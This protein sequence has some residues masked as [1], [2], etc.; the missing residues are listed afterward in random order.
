MI[1][2]IQSVP[3]K[4][5]IPR[6]LVFFYVATSYIILIF[7][8]FPIHLAF[9]WL[10]KYSTIKKSVSR[11]HLILSL[12]KFFQTSRLPLVLLEE[13]SGFIHGNQKI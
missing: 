9:C 1:L 11:R 7:F 6:Y 10:H 3:Q 2:F 13:V 4:R 8:S 12:A 5:D